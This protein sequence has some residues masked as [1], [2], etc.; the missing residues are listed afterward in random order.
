[1]AAQRA[2]PP[3]DRIPP[4]KEAPVNQRPAL[5]AYLDLTMAMILV[6]SSVAAGKFM[7]QELPVHLASA[8][9]FCCAALLI[10]PLLLILEGIPRLSLRSWAILFVQAACGSFLFN[11]FLL[12]GLARTTAGAAGIITSTT[13]ACMGLTAFAVLGERPSRRVVAGIALS[14][15]GILAVNLHDAGPDV[16]ADMGALAGNLLVLCAVMAETF[17]LLLRKCIPEPVSPLAVSTVMTVFGLALF[18]PGALVQARGFDFA[19][20]SWASWSVVAYYGAFVTV[21]A[22]LFWFSGVARVGAGTAGV[23]TAVMPVSALILSALLLGEAVTPAALAGCALV[24]AGI[25]CISAPA[26]RGPGRGRETRAAA[27]GR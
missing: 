18:T 22:Y 23:F 2:P 13:P 15:A 19:A 27:R 10:V 5:R 1:M 16:G 26:R 4:P 21:A 8:L 17:F 11:V 20:V 3:M 24:L 7:I 12:A 6:G 9:R 25:A 14:M